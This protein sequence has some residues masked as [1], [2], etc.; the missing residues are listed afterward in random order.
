MFRHKPKRLH[1]GDRVAH[2]SLDDPKGWAKAG[3]VEEV[4][5]EDA[6][7]LVVARWEGET[8]LI[9]YDRREVIPLVGPEARLGP[10]VLYPRHLWAALRQPRGAL[11]ICVAV[12]GAIALNVLS[13]ADHWHRSQTVDIGVVSIMAVIVVFGSLE[14]RLR[15]V[16]ARAAQPSRPNQPARPKAPSA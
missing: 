7:G 11:A 8:D 12:F 6:A 3:V 9:G 5:G 14:W 15:R 2:A 4:I 10:V 16:A 13:S 1:R